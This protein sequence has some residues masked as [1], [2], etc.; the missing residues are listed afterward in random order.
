M[1]HRAAEAD[2]ILKG[3][4]WQEVMSSARQRLKDQ[5]AVE[6]S[7]AGREILWHKYQGL[8]EAEVELKRLR[9]Q[10]VMEQTQND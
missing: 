5:W 9:D 4:L 7:A 2:R 6:G 10:G 8:T 3:D 1:N